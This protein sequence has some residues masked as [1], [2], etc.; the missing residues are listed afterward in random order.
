MAVSISQKKYVSRISKHKLELV[1]E[2]W[3]PRSRL[4]TEIMGEEKKKIK[5]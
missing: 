4:Q 5:P 2:E 3:I 1:S